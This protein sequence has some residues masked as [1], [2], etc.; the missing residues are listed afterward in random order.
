MKPPEMPPNLENLKHA[1]KLVLS[2]RPRKIQQGQEIYQNIL[3]VT[4]CQAGI[5]RNMALCDLQ[6][7]DLRGAVV[8]LEAALRDCSNY[9]PAANLLMDC[10]WRIGGKEEEMKELRSTF[11]V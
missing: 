4:G 2:K 5:R 7:N 1:N 10:Y 8:A 9:E 11:A 6:K 3:A